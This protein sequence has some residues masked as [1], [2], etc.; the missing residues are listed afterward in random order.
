MNT[1]LE[2]LKITLPALIVAAVVGL[3]VRAFLR[4]EQATLSAMLHRQNE[5][6]RLDLLKETKKVTI[7]LRLQAYE[8]LTI[9][10]NR[11]ELGGLVTRTNTTETMSGHLYKTIL[12]QTIEEEFTHNI[13]QQVYMTAELWNIIGIAKQEATAIIEKVYQ[14]LHP[15]KASA[16]DFLQALVA[17]LSD[18]P[19]GGYTQAMLAIKTEVAV[20]FE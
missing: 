4:K 1:V 11:L 10:C 18:H 9:F 19:Q 2:I 17:Y 16:K 20:M 14:N 8:R 12:Q 6:R 5:N 3:L 7:P 15:E 13:T